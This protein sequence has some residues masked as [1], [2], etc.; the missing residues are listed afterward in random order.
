MA[1]KKPHTFT[2][3]TTV[4]DETKYWFYGFEQTTG[5]TDYKMTLGTLKGIVQGTFDGTFLSLTDTPV[6]YETNSNKLTKVNSSENALIFTRITEDTDGLIRIN[7]NTANGSNALEIRDNNSALNSVITDSGIIRLK[8]PS[9]ATYFEMYV[10]GA[11]SSSNRII[12]AKS[13]ALI[14]KSYGSTA[15]DFYDASNARFWRNMQI[16]GYGHF[17]TTGIYIGNGSGGVVESQLFISPIGASTSKG[18]RLSTYNIL[19]SQFGAMSLFSNDTAGFN[20]GSDTTLTIGNLFELKNTSTPYGINVCS[21]TI[22]GVVT[23]STSAHYTK[24]FKNGGK[25]SINSIEYTIATVDTDSQ[26]TLLGYAAGVQT[27]VP[28]RLVDN[29]GVQLSVDKFGQTKIGGGTASEKFDVAGNINTSGVIKVD[30]VQVLKEQLTGVSAMTNLTAPANLDADTV[31]V[32]ELADIVGNLINKLR[33][34]GL[35][36]T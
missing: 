16:N 10:E 30:N 2:D 31:T 19:S 32:A 5:Y 22:G 34:H 13:G 21:V 8:Y 35:V 27:N 29:L 14:F 23:T 6:F 4:R 3:K 9:G 12:D 15:L 20:L 24:L 17:T 36:T 25:I 7:K 33:E 11:F 18:M 1:F 26:I 28:F